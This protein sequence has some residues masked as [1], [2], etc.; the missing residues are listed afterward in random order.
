MR[1]TVF[2]FV[3]PFYESAAALLGTLSTQSTGENGAR[4]NSLLALLGASQ[5]L[6]CWIKQELVR[7]AQTDH[8]FRVLAHIAADRSANSALEIASATGLSVP[9]VAGALGRLEV[10]GLIAQRCQSRHRAEF[11]LSLTPTGRKAFTAACREM[12][13]SLA[14]V[15]SDFSARE[16]GTLRRV[17][18]HLEE[19]LNRDLACLGK[20][21]R[22]RSPA[23]RIGRRTVRSASK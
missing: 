12:T 1:Y 5:H 8:G 18:T 19:E 21:R 15:V 11:T 13:A 23:A 17:C 20:P 7:S 4:L 3:L 6:S 9:V 16:L 2:V 22:R 14:R 10:S